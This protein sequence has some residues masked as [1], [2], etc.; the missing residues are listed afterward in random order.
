MF[1]AIRRAV[2]EGSKPFNGGPNTNTQTGTWPWS[3]IVIH[4]VNWVVILFGTGFL[5]WWATEHHL[6]RWQF[7]GTFLLAGLPHYFLAYSRAIHSA[8]S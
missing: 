6:S 7:I 4:S 1:V 5:I 8:S 3:W 2:D